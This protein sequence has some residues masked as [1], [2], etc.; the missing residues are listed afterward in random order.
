MIGL[1]LLVLTAFIVIRLVSDVPQLVHGTLPDDDYAR[2]YVE[3]PWTAYL[4]IAAGAAF[5]V[6]ALLQ[7][8]YRVRRRSYALHRR[9]GRVLVPLG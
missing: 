3:H 9:R 4:H 8:P 7:L 6:G 2:R 1:L 5:L